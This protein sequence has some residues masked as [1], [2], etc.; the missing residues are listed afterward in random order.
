VNSRSLAKVDRSGLETVHLAGREG[1]RLTRPSI[2]GDCHDHHLSLSAAASADWCS[3][4]V[5][6]GGEDSVHIMSVRLSVDSS[7]APCRVRL[8]GSARFHGALASVDYYVTSRNGLWCHRLQRRSIPTVRDLPGQSGSWPVV[9]SVKAKACCA[10]EFLPAALRE[11][12][13]AGI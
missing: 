12:Q 8:N 10:E 1:G 13:G 2:I 5:S 9:F 11:A 4:A 3:R 7:T 6:V